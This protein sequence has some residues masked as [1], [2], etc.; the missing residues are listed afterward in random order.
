M[1]TRTKQA[2]Q[3]LIN[4]FCGQAAVAAAINVK[5][6]TVSAWLSGEHGISAKNALK[7]QSVTG[8]SVKA[9]DLCPDLRPEPIPK[10]V[11]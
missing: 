10:K 2:V 4:Y 6:P 3:A 5:Q 8:G 1:D 7:A 11:A 9:D